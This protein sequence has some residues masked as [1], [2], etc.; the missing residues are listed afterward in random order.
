MY[1][2]PITA[3]RP[4]QKARSKESAIEELLKCSG[5]QFDPE[6]VK[7]FVERIL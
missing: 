4:Y 7:V 1:S 2:T 3:S 6:I 5:T